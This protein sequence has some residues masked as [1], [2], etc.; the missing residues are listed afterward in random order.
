MS[1][2]QKKFF[3]RVIFPIAVLFLIGCAS[4]YKA[5]SK[6]QKQFENGNIDIAAE[7]LEKNRDDAEGKNR[8]LYFLRC[9]VVY[10]MLGD[11]EKSNEYLE[12]A[13]L[14]AED[15]RKNYSLELLSLFTN[16]TVK[17]YTGED[18]E[19]VLIHYYKALNYL[20]MNQ[21][22]EALVECRRI[23]IKLN[24]LND[25]YG[26]HKNRYSRDAFAHNLMGIIYEAAGEYN[27][28]FI[29]Y[30]NAYEV[31]RD[32]Y[33]RLFG[34]DPP[35]QLKTDLLRA[36]YLNGFYEELNY[37]QQEFGMEYT[38]EENSGGELVFFWHNGLGPVKDEWSI[39]FVLVKGS[40]GLVNFV[41]EEQGLSFA[42]NTYQY[43]YS[44]SAD[45]SDLKAIRVAFPK[46][47]E[48]PPYYAYSEL[49]TGE[50]SYPLEPVE[51]INNIAF[52]TLQDRMIREFANSLLR[53]AV[54]QVSEELV[55]KKNENLGTL[56]SIF[57][58]LTE[59]ADTRN[60]QTLPYSISYARIP[61]PVGENTVKL[62]TVSRQSGESQLENFQFE[63]QKGETIFYVYHSLESY[64]A[65]SRTFKK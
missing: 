20:L 60:W 40:G 25:K 14:F 15:I 35:Q 33:S 22:D 28:A 1:H 44:R 5:H 55:R 48:R 65:G 50:G 23:N 51:N 30:R 3:T 26:K 61:L 36:A 64:P 13:Y 63:V 31:Y 16:P 39:N 18:F 12:K 42:F 2:L 27:D 43:P 32:D 59:K 41:N 38:H 11:Y 46:Y 24:K 53:L 56:V 21:Y 52:K 19:I 29:A 6:F 57:N 45:F 58:S 7:I 62:K 8:L 34:I 17:P 10:Q 47:V 9:G 4:Y 54:K 49:V 37:Y